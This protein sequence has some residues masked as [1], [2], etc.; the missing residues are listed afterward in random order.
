MIRVWR[1][2]GRSGR[3]CSDEVQGG[4]GHR[5]TLGADRQSGAGQ[6]TYPQA[7]GLMGLPPTPSRPGGRGA[8]PQWSVERKYTWNQAFKRDADGRA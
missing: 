1:Q 7:N 6:H 2:G 3:R 4:K 8:G 5:G